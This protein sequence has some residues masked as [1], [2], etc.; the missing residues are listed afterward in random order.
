MDAAIRLILHCFFFP[1]LYCHRWDK[2]ARGAFVVSV[3]IAALFF[4]IP[5][6]PVYSTQ[7]RRLSAQTK[8][9]S[10]AIAFIEPQTL[11]ENMYSA[12]QARERAAVNNTFCLF[13]FAA[14]IKRRHWKKCDRV[15]KDFTVIPLF[16]F[17][18]SLWLFVSSS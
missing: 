16:F 7:N 12:I 6:S 8:P 18:F 2:S 4:M 3:L 9:Q 17:F 10:R 14:H 13:Q 5:M 11:Y 15:A 1:F